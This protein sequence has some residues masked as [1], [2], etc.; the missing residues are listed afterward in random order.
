M[1]PNR[2]ME[3]MTAI[4]QRFIVAAS[5]CVA[6]HAAQAAPGDCYLSVGS[7]TY[8][9]GPCNIDVQTD[10]SFSIGTGETTRSPFFAYVFIDA[11]GKASASWNAAEGSNHADA[12]WRRDAPGRM[13][14]QH[15]CESVC[16]A[17]GNE[18]EDFLTAAAVRSRLR[19]R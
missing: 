17:A 18:A 9:D 4:P 12:D 2:R 3:S 5:L 7:F 8:L 14:G 19:M 15:E 13:L 6:S 1:K 11:G 10:G 16:M